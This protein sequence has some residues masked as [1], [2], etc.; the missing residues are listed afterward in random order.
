MLLDG[1][2]SL[3]FVRIALIE[4]VKSG[5]WVVRGNEEDKQQRDT[6]AARG[7][8][9]AFQAVKNSMQKIFDGENAGKF[10]K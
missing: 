7:Y 10:A 5:N 4:R 9:Q 2:H 8:W 3:I 1:W 6:L